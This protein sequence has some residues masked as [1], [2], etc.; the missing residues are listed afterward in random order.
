MLFFLLLLLF[1][2]P[3]LELSH[4]WR[5]DS[6]TVIW[7]ENRSARARLPASFCSYQNHG[8]DLSSDQN[9]ERKSQAANQRSCIWRHGTTCALRTHYRSFFN[10]R[11][12]KWGEPRTSDRDS[13]SWLLFAVEYIA[14]VLICES[15]LI[16]PWSETWA[17]AYTADQSCWLIYK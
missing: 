5:M 12:C 11:N 8:P 15:S 4:G 1:F 14:S 17:W 3:G 7:S 16:S 13:H 2:A 9:Q 10:L 6:G